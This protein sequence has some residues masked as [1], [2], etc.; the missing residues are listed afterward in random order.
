MA[1][2]AVRCWESSTCSK[3]FSKVAQPESKAVSAKD[4]DAAGDAM[5]P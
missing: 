4:D 2:A 1:A 3:Q 5:S